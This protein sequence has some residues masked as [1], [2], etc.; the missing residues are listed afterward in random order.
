MS[1]NFSIFHKVFP[2]PLARM[3]GALLGLVFLSFQ[4]YHLAPVE[5]GKQLIAVSIFNQ[6]QTI[7]WVVVFLFGFIC[8]I[9]SLLVIFKMNANHRF[10]EGESFPLAIFLIVALSSFPAV[11]MQPELL[12]TS[13]LGILIVSLLL[14]IYNQNLIAGIIFQASFL[15]SVAVLFYSPSIIFTVITLI[16]VSIFR[17]FDI[18]NLLLICIGFILLYVYLFGLSYIFE[19]EL[20]LPI[21]Y[22]D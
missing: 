11:F 5:A 4:A 17:P 10:A 20:Q 9:S 15:C 8:I 21:I 13:F 18:R 7:P 16:G 1:L 12:F 3:I 2:S 19:W 14:N 6:E 22:K